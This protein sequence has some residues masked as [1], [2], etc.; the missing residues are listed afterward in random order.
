MKKYFGGFGFKFGHNGF[1]HGPG[2]FSKNEK[3][4]WYQRLKEFLSYS[5][6]TLKKMVQYISI[7]FGSQD[8]PNLNP[9]NDFSYEITPEGRDFLK[10][11]ASSGVYHEYPEVLFVGT[12]FCFIVL[13]LFV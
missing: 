8:C 1:Y 2:D 12:G 5:A 6:E 4:G 7:L 9:F 11:G 13:Q 10:D 3:G